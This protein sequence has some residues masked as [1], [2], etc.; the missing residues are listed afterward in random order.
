MHYCFLSTGTWAGNASFVRLREFGHELSKRGHA[1]SYV[2]DEMESNRADLKLPA[3]ANIA[4]VP[5]G[6]KHEMPERRRAVK[7]LSPDFVHVLNPYIKAY[8][9]LAGTS[10]PVVGDWDEW[11]SRRPH[12]FGKKQVEMY[13]DRWLRKRS[14]RLIVC[15]RYLQNEFKKV[16]NLDTAYIPYATYLEPKQ[17]GESPFTRPTAVYMGNIYPAYDHDLIIE[18]GAI[19]Q[20]Q[21][22]IAPITLLGAGPDLEKWQAVVKDRKLTNVE[23]KG[24]VTGDILWRHLRHAHVLLFPIRETL[25]NLCRCP[26]KTFAYMQAKRPI[27]TNKV[28]EVAEAL[29]DKVRYV[30]CSP[31]AFA[32]AISESM[33]GDRQLPD[34]DY[35]VEKHSWALRTDSLLQALG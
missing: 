15:S 34:I 8:L 5:R 30:D 7:K 35:Q 24:Y 21:G 12:R 27:I 6:T 14:K 13:L 17:D 9:A 23:L 4:W 26:S 1:V 31:Q 10:Q 22:V 3:N 29:G 28:G 25:L 16:F 18:A 32:T 11:P 19:L 20:Q 33:Q 2:I